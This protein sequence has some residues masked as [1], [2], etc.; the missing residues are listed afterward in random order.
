MASLAR[1]KATP[2]N[3]LRGMTDDALDLLGWDYP[4]DFFGNPA[5]MLKDI[6]LPL[7]REAIASPADFIDA[8]I[9]AM[10]GGRVPSLPM[11]PRPE[12]FAPRGEDGVPMFGQLP[13]FPPVPGTLAQGYYYQDKD[14]GKPQQEEKRYYKTKP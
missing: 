7:P 1:V 4:E 11:L 12:Q 8:G 14:K 10:R 6:G 2:D 3:P 13:P 9:K 5:D